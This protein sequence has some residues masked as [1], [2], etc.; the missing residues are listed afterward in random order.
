MNNVPSG[1]TPQPNVTMNGDDPPA[2]KGVGNAAMPG[3]GTGD[4]DG[5]EG[6]ADGEGN[7]ITVGN[8]RVP[9]RSTKW[10]LNPRTKKPPCRPTHKRI[11][12]G[13]RVKHP[14]EGRN[15]G[16]TAAGSTVTAV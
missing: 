8:V 16:R 12:K 10:N 5:I 7:G 1:M 13:G 2:G 3:I 11:E 14:P 4:E 9:K 6:V 15:S